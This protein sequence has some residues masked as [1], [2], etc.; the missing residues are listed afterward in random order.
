MMQL[1]KPLE[2]SGGTAF[3]TLLDTASNLQTPGGSSLESDAAAARKPFDTPGGP[4]AGVVD[5]SGKIG[6]IDPNAPE[7]G[8]GG[9]PIA[10]PNEPTVEEII[11]NIMARAQRL[12]W[13]AKKLKHLEKNLRNLDLDQNDY[14]GAT[15]D[16]VKRV[17][18]TVEARSLDKILARD[19]ARGQGPSLPPGQMQTNYN[20]CTIFAIANAARLP[21]PVVAAQATEVVKDAGYRSIAEKADPQKTIETRGLKGPELI[22]VVETFGQAQLVAPA[23]F[24]QTLMNRKP[25]IVGLEYPTGDPNNPVGGHA[26]V[27]TKTFLH[28]GDRWY[29]MMNSQESPWKRQYLSEDE[30]RTILSC[31]GIVYNPEPGTVVKQL[32]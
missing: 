21:Y 10:R 19:L 1:Y 26:V 20:D 6:V 8:G 31:K 29:E 9:T 24:V 25:I 18:Q 3:K 11:K 27:L 22:T 17:W 23:D 12:G 14:F 4:G 28:N 30:L 7:L 2:G 13:S 15:P 5:L 32:K 16:Q